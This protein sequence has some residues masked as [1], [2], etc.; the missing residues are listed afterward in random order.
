M[1]IKRLFTKHNKKI[2]KDVRLQ[3]KLK[4]TKIKKIGRNRKKMQKTVRKKLRINQ[5]K[6]SERDEIIF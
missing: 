6:L 2:G 3:A 1:Q 5:L 4:K